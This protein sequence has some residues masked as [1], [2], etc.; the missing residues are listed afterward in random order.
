[1]AC[2]FVPQQPIFGADESPIFGTDEIPTFGQ[3]PPCTAT[4]R[5][6]FACCAL[7]ALGSDQTYNF[8]QDERAIRQSVADAYF[9]ADLMLEQREK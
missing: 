2:A 3:L 5:D 1:M 9:I 8:Y 7:T 6:E 4:L